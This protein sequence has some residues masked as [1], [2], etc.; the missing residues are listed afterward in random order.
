MNTC[1]VP[2]IQM[3]PQCFT[4]ATIR[5]SLLSASKQ[6]P[7]ALVVCDSLLHGWCHVKLLPFRRTFCVHH[8]TTHHL[9]CHFIR[10]H[11]RRVHVCS[12]VTCH[13]HV[14]HNVRCL[15][16]TTAVTWP[17][18]RYRSKSQHKNVDPREENC[19]AARTG[20]EPATFRSRI[21]RSTAELCPP[22]NNNDLKEIRIQMAAKIVTERG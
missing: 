6:T 17:W 9:H 8:T 7:C 2:Q 5:R 22:P 19:S 13:F 10:S 20:L 11:I 1:R 4:L 12:A 15:L 21:R 3:I 14:W 18:N 16:R